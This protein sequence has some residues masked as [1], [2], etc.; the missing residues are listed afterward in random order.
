[1][2]NKTTPQG[3]HGNKEN[4]DHGQNRD[5]LTKSQ[6]SLLIF[7]LGAEACCLMYFFFHAE[8]MYAEVK[9]MM[10]ITCLLRNVGLY[11][12][13]QLPHI[14][15]KIEG[16]FTVIFL[17]LFISHFAFFHDWKYGFYICDSTCIV[18]IAEIIIT[19]IYTRIL[20]LVFNILAS[21]NA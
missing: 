4:L 14:V 21:R 2:E 13:Y 9:V 18:I 16:Y 11:H 15:S 7:F 12:L 1:M 20:C 17:L 6:K 8:S 5:Q 3:S 10:S 19:I